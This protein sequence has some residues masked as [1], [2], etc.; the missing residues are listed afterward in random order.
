MQKFAPAMIVAQWFKKGHI[1][2]QENFY[3]FPNFLFFL[4]FRE[5][6]FI[7]GYTRC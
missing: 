3:F 4:N 2:A 1:V 7:H 6:R 5:S